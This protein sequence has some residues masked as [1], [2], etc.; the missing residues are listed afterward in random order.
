MDET[1]TIK[2]SACRSET[3]HNEETGETIDVY[4]LAKS[5]HH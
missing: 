2:I 3:G 5:T 4:T 1:N